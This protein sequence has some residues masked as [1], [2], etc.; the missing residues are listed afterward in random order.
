MKKRPSGRFFR[1]R[2][3]GYPLL[4]I[5]A[6][7]LIRHGAPGAEKPGLI[8]SDGL[9]RDLS[10]LL[11]DFDPVHLSPRTLAALHLLDA[12]RLPVL[13]PQ[14]RLGCPVSGVG[15][16]VCVGLNYADHARETGAAIPSEPV[17]FLKA[18]SALNGPNDAIILPPDSVKTDWEVELGVVIGTTAR[19]V[20]TDH[21]MDHIA[22]YVLVNDV[23]ERSYQKERGGT[24]DKGKGCDTFAPVGP[25]LVTPDEIADPHDLPI[26]L[27][28]NGRRMQDSSTRELI[29]R[30]PTLIAYISRFMTLMPGD[31]VSTGTPSGVGLGQHPQ[32][33][34]LQPGDA[35]RLGISGLGEQQQLCIRAPDQR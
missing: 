26:W 22:G 24:W 23:S 11:P 10:M 12:D 18:P 1:L 20:H 4:I 34:F 14:I 19:H 9:P 17:L 35:M 5:D 7:K 33:I 13:D 29:F 32:P 16:I 31:I 2:L 25:W 15:K 30:I 28:V 21:A 6:M 3:C 8:G 27:E